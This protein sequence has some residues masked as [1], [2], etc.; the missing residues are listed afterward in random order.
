MKIVGG[1]HLKDAH[2]I[3]FDKLHVLDSYKLD[4]K[5]FAPISNPAKHKKAV[6]NA[7]DKIQDAG[8][9]GNKLAIFA[10]AARNLE[11]VCWPGVPGEFLCPEE[12]SKVGRSLTNPTIM[13]DPYATFAYFGTQQATSTMAI[14]KTINK[15]KSEGA[16][17]PSDTPSKKPTVYKTTLMPAW[18]VLAHE[19]GHYYHYIHQNAWFIKCL[20][21][22]DIAGIEE[23]N[24]ADHETPI[25][26]EI[27]L[28]PRANYQDFR[29]GAND[30]ADKHIQWSGMPHG[31]SKLCA[32]ISPD[33][34]KD[35]EAFDT[36][37]K[38]KERLKAES[39]R[40]Q[41]VQ[42]T[43]K[44]MGKVKCPKCNKMVREKALS[45]DCKNFLHN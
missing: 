40:K 8:F 9:V 45:I 4:I 43:A 3:S 16:A 22:G 32:P 36:L 15:L 29:G 26:M 13:W 39:D 7:L 2:L 38:E 17:S 41:K 6:N 21:S 19:I 14:S 25:L 42:T 27:G 44:P 10:R 18:V 5:N 35:K 30:T 37:L 28:P 34:Q 11:I 12:A 1:D 31:D 33:L 24:L 23:K 20:N